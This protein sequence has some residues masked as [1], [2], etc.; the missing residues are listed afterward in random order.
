MIVVAV[1][2]LEDLGLRHLHLS[3]G[4]R[5]A[6]YDREILAMVRAVRETSSLQIEV[7]LGP[8]LGRQTVRALRD[9]GVRSITSSL[10]TINEGVFRDAKPGDTFEGRMALLDMAD[11]EGLPTRAMMLL[12]LGE[13]LADRIR[14]LFHFRKFRRLHQIRF[15]RFNPGPG[16]PYQDKPRCSPWELART[17]AV[18]RLIHPAVE[19][20]M[21]AGNTH[22]DIPLWFLAGGGNQLLGASVNR[23][24]KK[25]DAGTETM[26]LPHGLVLSNRMASMTR[27]VQGM[28][29]SVSF[30]PP[31]RA[32]A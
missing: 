14:F 18:A 10:E 25:P 2:A 22:D 4:T 31:R 3:G 27:Q 23:S 6:G 16:T 26:A 20:G 17:V 11:E 13:S 5:L 30:A 21:A 7:N 9:L 8:S 1:K 32:C 24:S 12:G 29:L 15:S 28:G 19:L